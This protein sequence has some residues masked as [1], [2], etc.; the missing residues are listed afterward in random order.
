MSRL[1]G[2]ARGLARARD[3]A[4]ADA[5]QDHHRRVRPALARRLPAADHQ[6]AEARRGQRARHHLRGAPAGRLH[7]AVQ[8]RRIPGRRQRGA[9][10][11]GLADVRGVKVELPVQ[12]VRL[13]GRGRHHA[14]EVNTLKDLEGKE[15]AAA[16]STTNYMMFDW[17][18]QEAGR[19]HRQDRG[20]QHG[21]AGPDRLCAGRPRRRGPAVGAG[22]HIL[23][24]PRSRRSARST[25]GIARRGTRSPAAARIP[26]LGVAAHIDWIEQNKALM[27][28]LYKAYRQAAEWIAANPDEAAKLIMPKA[29]AGGPEGAGRH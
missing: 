17:S 29:H 21:N 15:L 8:F 5:G 6:G 11:V 20:G 19:R 1:P 10:D 22:L 26:Y 25:D 18:G 14:A 27:P 7:R 13:L 28:R 9:D 3:R 16:R 12:P 24:S 4:R 23:I 2:L